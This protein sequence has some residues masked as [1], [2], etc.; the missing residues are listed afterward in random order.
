[1]EQIE[2]TLVLYPRNKKLTDLDNVCSIHT[3]Y[4]SDCLVELGK[5]P[6]D[7]YKHLTKI[8]YLFGEVDKTNPRVE[9][10]IKDLTPMKITFTLSEALDIIRAH[11]PIFENAQLV[12][13]GL[14][15][16]PLTKS[17][18]EVVLDT[19]T[20]VKRKRRSKAEIEAANASIEEQ[21]TDT[22]EP[23]S[24]GSETPNNTVGVN[25]PI[26]SSS[27]SFEEIN[28]DEEPI[29]MGQSLFGGEGESAMIDEVLSQDYEDEIALVEEDD[30]IDLTKPMFG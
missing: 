7:N 20:K 15:D 12:I 14:N 16:Q 3:K 21:S 8:T 13:E 9:I 30:V 24:V 23:V 2:L 11:D 28:E 6:D 25:E 27:E 4:F 26:F 18:A 19:P 1:M 22:N 17:S 5:L 29:V 10:F